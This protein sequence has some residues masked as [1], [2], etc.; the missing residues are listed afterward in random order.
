MDRYSAVIL[1]VWIATAACWNGTTV[2]ARTA[3]WATILASLVTIFALL[4]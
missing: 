1:G 3:N 2:L 4:A